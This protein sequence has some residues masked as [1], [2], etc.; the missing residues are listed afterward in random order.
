MR[1]DDGTTGSTVT[2]VRPVAE[3][4]REI[5]VRAIAD[6]QLSPSVTVPQVRGYLRG[7]GHSCTP[8]QARAVLEGLRGDLR[9]GRFGERGR[10]ESLGSRLAVARKGRYLSRAELAGMVGC[11]ESYLSYLETGARSPSS[12][13]LAALAEAVGR[14][15]EWLRFG[16]ASQATARIGAL[17]RDCRRAMDEGKLTDAERCLGE[18]SGHSPGRALTPDER[19][20]VVLLRSLLLIRRGRDPEAVALLE[21]LV[22]RMLAA[23]SS[24]SSAVVCPV[25]LGQAYLTAVRAEWSEGLTTPARFHDV[26]ARTRRLLVITRHLSRDDGWWRLAA[27]VMGCECMIGNIQPGIA[28]AKAWLAELEPGGGG[29]TSGAAALRWNLGQALAENGEF[30]EALPHLAVAV[31]LHDGE[32]YE[33]EGVRLRM[34]YAEVLM[35]ACPEKVQSA[36]TILESIWSDDLPIRDRLAWRLHRARAELVALRPGTVLEIVEPLLATG[37]PDVLLRGAAWQAVG[38]AHALGQEGEAAREAYANVR[39][40]L[41]RSTE[42]RGLA[43]RWRNLADRLLAVD[44]PDPALDAYRR[45]LTLLDLPELS[46]LPPYR[47]G[48]SPPGAG[49]GPTPAEGGRR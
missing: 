9:E 29:V 41:L 28:Q 4:L 19:D 22:S 12:V 18:L 46:G 21:P 40:L 31:R 2:V 43:R 13:M 30:A 39:K 32:R 17:I 44:A 23:G 47:T 37:M 5:V 26:L 24:T 7:R 6:G 14:E 48:G 33:H 20:R 27:T 16:I 45:A 25:E 15:P 1:D 3:G 36:I 34:T 35:T 10:G 49:T 42:H 38:D 8:L 11:S